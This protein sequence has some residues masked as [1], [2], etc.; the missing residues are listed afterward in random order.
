[1]HEMSD[2]LGH[3]REKATIAHHS[4]SLDLLVMTLDKPHMRESGFEIHPAWK[5]FCVEH[6]PGQCSM[7]RDVRIDLVGQALKISHCKRSV[8][9][10]NEYPFR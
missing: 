3:F 1:M 9:F 5:R 10:E 4:Q 2:D 6:Q 7:F 8:G